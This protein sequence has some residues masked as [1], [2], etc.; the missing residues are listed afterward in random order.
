MTLKCPTCRRRFTVE[1]ETCQRCGT[2]LTQLIELYLQ[3]LA[4]V[5]MGYSLLKSDP[6]SALDCFLKAE[7]IIKDDP[8]V[9]K[10]KALAALLLGDFKEAMKLHS[11]VH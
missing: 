11:K 9:T 10:G 7:E 2:A 3:H 6:A 4:Q 5:E 8:K 1:T